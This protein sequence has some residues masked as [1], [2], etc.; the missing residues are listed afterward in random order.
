[1]SSY[2]T[3]ADLA[4][5]MQALSRANRAFDVRYPGIR[6]D[7]L[8][9][10]TLYGGAHLFKH[11]TPA[12]L[13]DLALRHLQSFAADGAALAAA[14]EIS[15]DELPLLD[16]VYARVV[17]KLEREA[18]EDQRLDFEDG[19]GARA[20]EEEDGHAVAAAIEL[21]TGVREDSLPAFIG[22]RVKSL[23]EETRVRSIRTLDLFLS[24]FAAQGTGLPQPFFVTLPK[25]THPGQVAALVQCLD[26]L[27]RRCGFDSGSIS[28]EIM[29]ETI[30]SIISP[31]GENAIPALADAGA[32]RIT[33]AI[34]G[35]YDYTASCNIASHYQDH[36]HPAADFARQMM[37]V[38]LTGTAVNICDG[39]T[40]TMPIPP[41]RGDALTP[42][43]QQ[44][45]RDVVHQAWRVHWHNILHSLRLGF[46]QGWDLNPA[47]IPIRF[48]ACY[49]FFLKGLD[50]AS[51]RLK[52]F[53]D[54]ATQASMVGNTFDDA[55]SAQGLLNYFVNGINCGALTEAEA[56]GTGITREELHARSFQ[57]IVENRLETKND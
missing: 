6:L 19:Y 20:D 57:Q 5:V 8:P 33:S 2:L 17:D 12:K 28:I 9:V 22:V 15:S 11:T 10:H 43:Q 41:H 3:D 31:T 1:M 52:T 48:A 30:Q 16:K 40:N 23:S 49:Y 7:R 34:L 53:M 47:Q 36:R 55:A 44:E 38:C 46:Y 14:L 32:G 54:Q 4:P 25:V 42:A 39:I 24:T 29:I 56:L 37:Q 26:L 51:A 45:N 13:S 27:E 35:T 18:I 21:A 50:D